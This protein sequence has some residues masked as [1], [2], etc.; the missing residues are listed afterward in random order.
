MRI[1]GMSVNRKLKVSF[2]SPVILG[3]AIL[4]FAAMVLDFITRGAANHAFFSVYRSSL[5]SPLTYVRLFGH[6]LGHAGWAHFFGNI[7]L[8]LVV[9]PLLEEKYG[10]ANLLFVILAT[11]LTTGLV[12][13]IFFP[14]VGLLG[15]S[16]VVFALILLSSFTSMKE[17]EIPLTFLLVAVIY[18]GQQVYE[19][20]FVHD[21]VSNLTHILGGVVGAGLGFVMNRNKMNRY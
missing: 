11:A 1:L 5:L 6:V 19:G 9:G 4:C 2:N 10:S 18:I 15:A 17:G 16:G 21:N 20:L 12:H 3:F 13:F 7:T 8:I 14:R